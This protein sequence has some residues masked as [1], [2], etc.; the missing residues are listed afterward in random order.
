MTNMI[1]F[2][3]KDCVNLYQKPISWLP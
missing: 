2:S 3:T 1:H